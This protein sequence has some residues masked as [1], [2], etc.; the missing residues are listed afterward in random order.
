MC[1]LNI[2]FFLA[3]DQVVSSLVWT[4]PMS[5]V[6]GISR[7]VGLV[8]YVC[9]P[10]LYAEIDRRALIKHRSLGHFTLTSLEITALHSMLLLDNE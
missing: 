8:R 10:T 6:S 5:E 7:R 3:A 9:S 4:M 1:E 2:S